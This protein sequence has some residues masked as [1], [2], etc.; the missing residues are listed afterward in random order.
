MKEKF[1]NFVEEK[2]L[3]KKSNNSYMEQEKYTLHI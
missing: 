2:Y 1:I 3:L